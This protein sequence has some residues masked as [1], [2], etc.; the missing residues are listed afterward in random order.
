MPC[1]EYS[2]RPLRCV[3]KLD[4]ACLRAL[5]VDDV[6]ETMRGLLAGADSSDSPADH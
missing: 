3:A 2:S 4:Y 1:F 5:A 6:L